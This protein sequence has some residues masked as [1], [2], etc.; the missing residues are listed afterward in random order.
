MVPNESSI[1][2]IKGRNL[3]FIIAGYLNV[4]QV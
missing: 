4:G 3:V 1:V 2:Y